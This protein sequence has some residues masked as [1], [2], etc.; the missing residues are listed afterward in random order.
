MQK[1]EDLTKYDPEKKKASALTGDSGIRDIQRQLRQ[2]VS[3]AAVGATGTYRNLAS[4]GVSFGA[5]GS[6]VGT[7]NRLVVDDAKLSKALAEN[8]QAVEAVLAGFAATLGAPDHDQHDRRQ[9]HA[10]DPPGRHY[11][12][13]VTDATPAPWRPSSSRQ[14]GARSGRPP[15][16][17]RP[18]RT[19]SP[20]S[21]ASRSRPQPTLTNGADGHLLGHA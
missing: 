14:T 8:P 1:I 2:M 21:L 10:P 13:K 20:S 18:A 9:R 15:A 7:T 17:W 16:R 3:S 12:I 19:T 5:V 6:A 4:I 11:N